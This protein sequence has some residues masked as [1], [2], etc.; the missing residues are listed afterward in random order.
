MT[1]VKLG[2]SNKGARYLSINRS[3][4]LFDFIATLVKTVVTIESESRLRL[5]TEDGPIYRIIF[6]PRSDSFDF[7]SLYS[8][9]SASIPEKYTH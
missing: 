8:L 1:G 2:E 6:K 3:K 7:L 4:S 5:L 9:E